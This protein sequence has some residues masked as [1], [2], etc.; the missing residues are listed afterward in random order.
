MNPT[1]RW[2]KIAV[3]GATGFVGSRLMAY[4]QNAG[5][6]V[7]PVTMPRVLA[8]PV[9][10]VAEGA[11][12]W[13]R[14]NQRPYRD[15]CGAL[16]SFDVVINAAGDGRSGSTDAVRL[17]ASNAVLPAIA[18]RAAAAAGV[19]RLLQ[20]STA[21]VQGRLDPL[22]ET[23]FH[24][25]L[26]AYARSKAASERWLLGARPDRGEV[27]PELVLYR[28]ASIQAIRHQATRSFARLVAH[29]PAVPVEGSGDRPVP[30]TLLDNVAA[31][32]FFAAAMAEPAPIILQPDE[33]ITVRRL[34]ELFGARRL[35]A[36]PPRATNL[37]LDQVERLTS[38]SAYL[39]SRLRWFDLL[40]RGQASAAKALPGAGFTLPVGFEGWEALAEA[41]KPN[42]RHP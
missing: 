21:A 15:L 13:C 29:L 24:F 22:D 40:L 23:A 33:G 5:V 32:I 3:L 42:R 9:G 39:T 17:H 37:A 12:R 18:A 30:V 31:G 28:P 41:N 1:A 19:R 27:P 7:T 6:D 10:D 8:G 36:L 25:P 16:A 20:V 38:H 2:P 4:G 35:V 11:A 14:V 26:F 34:V